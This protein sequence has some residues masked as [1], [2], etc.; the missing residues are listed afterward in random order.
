MYSSSSRNV[1][2]AGKN[3]YHGKKI[4]IPGAL[5]SITF[6]HAIITG[7][8]TTSVFLKSEISVSE[9]YLKKRIAYQIFSSIVEYILVLP[10]RELQEQ[11]L[12]LLVTDT[13]FCNVYTTSNA[14]IVSVHFYLQYQ[15]QNNICSEYAWEVH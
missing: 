9:L 2:Q 15:Q 8:D 6:L 4:I 7:C 14:C 11:N 5:L 12:H 13:F 3:N 1:L 10:Y